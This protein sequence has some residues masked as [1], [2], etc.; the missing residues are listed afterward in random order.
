MKELK[1]LLA[2]WASLLLLLLGSNQCLGL[3]GRG[4]QLQAQD[5]LHYAEKS[6]LPPSLE[7]LEDTLKRVIKILKHNREFSKS[8]VA[9][10]GGMAC[11]ITFRT[12]ERLLCNTLV[13]CFERLSG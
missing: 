7:E 12:A 1:F 2:I 4:A 13:P 6:V 3:L 5:T 8:K 10:V 11:G 9:V